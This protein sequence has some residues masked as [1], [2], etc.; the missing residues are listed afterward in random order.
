MIQHVYERA[1]MCREIQQVC[2]ATDDARILQEVRNFGGRAVMTAE[3]H[4]SGSDRIAE[5]ALTAGLDD[6]DLIVNIQGDQPLFTP[7]SI[8]DLL[9]PF[10]EKEAAVVMSTL[11]CR[12]TS[13]QEISDPNIVKVV[14]DREQW[15]L[16]FSR[17]PIPYYRDEGSEPVFY[18]HLGFYAYRLR[19]LKA[20]FRLA[21]GRLEV[22]EKLE[23]LR[24]LENGY[25]IKV[26]ET[27]YDSIEIDTPGDI[28]KVERI[29]AQR[30]AK[31]P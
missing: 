4:P 17:S 31:S 23:Q 27:P 13:R 1:C 6:D 5:A 8:A 10:Q 20:F 30:T 3:R 22:A 15:A 9:R 18:K 24:A 12:I 19:F 25:R 16:F 11:Q 2:V 21:P 7:A 29:L 26:V 28:E 14:T